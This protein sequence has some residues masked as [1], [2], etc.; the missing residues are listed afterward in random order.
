MTREVGG[1]FSNLP[2]ST[3]D[4]LCSEYKQE[5]GRGFSCS[6]VQFKLLFKKKSILFCS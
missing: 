5:A 1:R 3:E 2:N 4:F 6:F